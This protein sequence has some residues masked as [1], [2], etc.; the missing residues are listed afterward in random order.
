MRVLDFAKGS[1][2][3]TK[4]SCVSFTR[5]FR[6][7]ALANIRKPSVKLVHVSLVARNAILHTRLLGTLRIE[8]QIA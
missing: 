2:G 7:M 8:I 1:K 3:A 4:I 6:A 5:L